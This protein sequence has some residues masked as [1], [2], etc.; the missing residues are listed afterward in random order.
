MRLTRVTLFFVCLILGLGFYRLGDYLLEGVEAQTLQATEEAMVDMAHLLANFAEQ[1]GQIKNVFE[2]IE[3]RSFEARIFTILKKEVG[4][5]AYVFDAQGLILFD[6]G[7]P[8]HVG[9]SFLHWND[10]SQTLR[11]EYGAR[12]SR[13]DEADANS[14]VMYVGAPIRRGDEIIGGVSVYKRQSDVLQFSAE[15]RRAIIKATLLIGTGIFVLIISVFVWLFRP[16]G[17][18]TQYARSITRGDRPPLP[19]LGSGREVNTLAKSLFEMREALEG[20]KRI[21]HY[22][23][24]LTHELKSPLA[25]IRGASELLNEDLPTDE[26]VRFLRNITTQT[27]RCDDLIHKL[28]ELSALE[29]KTHLEQSHVFDLGSCARTSLQEMKPLAQSHHVQIKE[30]ISAEV[31]IAGS[32][33]LIGSA[34]KHLVENAIQFSSKEGTITLEVNAQGSVALVQVIDDGVGISKF[35][36]E[37]A[38]ER[39]Y[40]FR[41]EHQGKGN[42]L[43]LSLVWEIAKLHHG[44][45]FICRRDEG[46]TI[47]GIRIPL[48]PLS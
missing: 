27:S 43:G 17:K 5:H 16:I 42:G 7:Q 35:A 40:S 11:G 28:L 46:G 29:S 13:I 15:R 24:T 18:L 9:Q 20:R 21:D 26:K 36:A 25:A 19:K 30:S 44:E 31:K 10:V 12:S 38:F 34:I 14:S 32:E 41:P 6:S 1:N 45:A 3:N 23:Q 8:N 48:A 39:F 4:V 37:R 33:T 2:G 22:I 47:A